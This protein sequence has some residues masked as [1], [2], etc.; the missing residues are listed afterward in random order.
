MDAEFTKRYLPRSLP[1]WISKIEPINL[2][3]VCITITKSSSMQWTLATG[4][5]MS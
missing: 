1:K 5:Y 2:K 4:G 3:N